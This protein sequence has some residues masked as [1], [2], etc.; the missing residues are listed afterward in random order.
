MEYIAIYIIYIMGYDWEIIKYDT[1]ILYIYRDTHY[2][3]FLKKTM[4][5]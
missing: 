1:I 5:S 4:I 2:G 3:D